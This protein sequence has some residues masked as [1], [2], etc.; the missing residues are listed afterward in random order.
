MRHRRL[1]GLVLALVA[2]LIT[3]AENVEMQVYITG[4]GFGLALCSNDLCRV[5][6]CGQRPASWPA[7]WKG[8]SGSRMFCRRSSRSSKLG[9][10]QARA[11]REQLQLQ[12]A[13]GRV[14]E[15]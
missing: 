8:A 11:F 2:I 9:R 13:S 1:L 6:M 12:L 7:Q 14:K 3:G 10:T 5:A 4:R 15:E